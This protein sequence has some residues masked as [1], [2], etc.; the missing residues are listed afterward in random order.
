[1]DRQALIEEVKRFASSQEGDNPYHPTQIEGLGVMVSG[2]P[3]PIQAQV[4]QP[5]L[6]LVLQGEKETTAG[7]QQVRFGHGQSLIVS[8]ELPVLSQ[9]TE[10]QPDVPYVAMILL[11]DEDIIRSLFDEIRDVDIDSASQSAMATGEADDALIE[12]MGRL[13]ALNAKPLDAK[14]LA[15][16]IK[17]E[18]HYRMLM[19]NHGSMLRRLIE[20][21]SHADRIAKVI[22]QI[23]TNLAARFVVSELANTVG[24][25]QSS[26][27][28]HFKSITGMTPIQYQ[29][30]LRLL[31]ARRLLMGGA[32]TVSSVAYHVGYESPTQFSRE[33][34][35]KFGAS[36]SSELH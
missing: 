8:H 26:F 5:L 19:A 20:T 24:M 28:E 23:K 3:T 36:P 33:Y 21:G 2:Q 18:I 15:N 9:I 1:M 7:T 35:R 16:G 34:S 29:K 4:Y 30:E 32:N 25:S 12:S 17:K 27:H 14:L 22:N 6:C 13:F 10:A 31:E 11:L